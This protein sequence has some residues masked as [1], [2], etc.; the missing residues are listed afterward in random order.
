MAMV[1][2]S[3]SI[4]HLASQCNG[5]DNKCNNCHNLGGHNYYGPLNT[6]GYQKFLHPMVPGCDVTTEGLS[7]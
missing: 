2:E 6:L 1:S 3:L 7:L 5:H 4:V